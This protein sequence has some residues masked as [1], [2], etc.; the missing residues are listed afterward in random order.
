MKNVVPKVFGQGH[1]EVLVMRYKLN[2]HRKHAFWRRSK[3][4]WI[5]MDLPVSSWEKVN[6]NS[7]TGRS[8]LIWTTP[9]SMFTV[10]ILTELH[11]EP[12]LI[13]PVFEWSPETGRCEPEWPSTSWKVDKFVS[14]RRQRNAPIRKLDWP[15]DIV[16]WIYETLRLPV[17][18]R[19]E[20]HFRRNYEI[21]WGM[22]LVAAEN[23]SY[24]NRMTFF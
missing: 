10:S 9:K 7:K 23:G 16:E 24:D 3:Q 17:K 13:R 12:N 21:C 14:G 20:F 4:V 2:S 8:N 11:Y 15:D 5:R 22:T 18:K 19:L 6:N 1:G